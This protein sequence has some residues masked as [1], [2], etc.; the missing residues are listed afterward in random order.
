[1]ITTKQ[2]NGRQIYAQGGIGL[3][4]RTDVMTN[5]YTVEDASLEKQRMSENLERLLNYDKYLES[6]VVTDVIE[7]TTNKVEEYTQNDVDITPTDTTM[8]F[9]EL[10]SEIIRSELRVEENEQKANSK[11]KVYLIVYSVLVTVVLALIVLNTSILASISST[12]QAKQAQFD[13]LQAR[14]N[15]LQEE[16]NAISSD[17]YVINIAQNEYNMVK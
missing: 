4:E 7:E 13:N 8:Q 17:D 5:G 3:L 10:D 16:Y 1:M 11:G 12:N 2:E 6:D 9:G 14:Y 15:A